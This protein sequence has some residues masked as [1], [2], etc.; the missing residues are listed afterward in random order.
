MHLQ[1]VGTAY[2]HFTEHH[3]RKLEDWGLEL[4]S[5][6]SLLM[7]L[8][9]ACPGKIQRARSP[10]HLS[11]SVCYQYAVSSIWQ[12]LGG[13]TDFVPWFRAPKFLEKSQAEALSTFLS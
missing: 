13:W 8:S 4:D 3:P 5:S 10:G 2:P 6:E 11:I 9:G 12:L 7:L 1:S